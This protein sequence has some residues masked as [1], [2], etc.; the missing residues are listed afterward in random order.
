MKSLKDIKIFSLP[1]NAGDAVPERDIEALAMIEAACF[2]SPW[3]ESSF[4]DSLKNSNTVWRFFLI[5]YGDTPVGYGGVY[6][7]IDEAFITNIAVMPEFRRKGMASVIL[8][9]I[10]SYC[11]KSD[12]K[13]IMLEVR[14]SNEG[15]VSLYRKFGFAVDGI[16]KNHYSAP[17][18]DAFL[19]SLT[20]SDTL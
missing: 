19:M 16:S 20:I 2:S 12:I 7:V 1:E 4:R 17:S 9:S 8:E 6:S 10:I 18:E 11:R 5:R 3:K 15:A 14:V 13:R